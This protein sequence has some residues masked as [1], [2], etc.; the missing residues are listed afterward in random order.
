M[1]SDVDRSREEVYG[2]LARLFIRPPDETTVRSLMG[3]DAE[4]DT[5]TVAVE[6]TELL[7][8]IRQTSPPPPYESL[9]R[10]GVISGET[11][12]QVLEVY[13]AFGVHPDGTLEG[14]PA[15]H[16]SLE[17]DFMRHLVTLEGNAGTA[18]ELQTILK[19]EAKF[20]GEHLCQW[21]GGFHERI[22]VQDGTGFYSSVASFTDGWVE[23]DRRRV[24]LRL[25]AEEV[26]Q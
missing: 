21:V 26:A 22:A 20:L 1:M 15:D 7:R 10:E 13:H 9:Y 17:L 8:G 4:L 25:G 16:I 23:D 2:M 18:K 5:E 3:D 11:T 14:E 24:Q 6:F 19:A 12:D